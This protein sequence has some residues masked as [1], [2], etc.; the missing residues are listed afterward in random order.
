MKAY[1]ITIMDLPASVA[2][3][4]RC[5][6]SFE[7][8]NK[9][10]TVEKWRATT[11]KDQIYRIFKNK[12]I[13]SP[14]F[15]EQ[16]GSYI[17]NCMSAFMS[18]F[19]LWEQ[20]VI[21]NETILILEHDA[22]A[23]NSIPENF[24]KLYLYGTTQKLH[25]V[26]FGHPSYGQFQQPPKMG[27]QPLVSK[28]YFP[29]AHAY[30]VSPEGAQSLIEHATQTAMAGPTDVYLNI[31]NFP[32]LQEY[33]PWPVEA[34]D[35]FTTIQRDVGCRAKHNWSDKYGIIQVP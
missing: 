1:V 9:H 13:E 27:F 29:G 22:V 10:I 8:T 34:R 14:Y 33:Y 11:P 30:S 19:R 32:W 26:N 6:K 5:I 16:G 23:V 18:H 7:R 25:I 3:A 24:D 2:A 28:G 31:Q 4:N 35:N 17:K 12:G 21:L 15:N 20:S